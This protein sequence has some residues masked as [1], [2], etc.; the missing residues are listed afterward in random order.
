MCVTVS[1]CVRICVLYLLGREAFVLVCASNFDW[2]PKRLRSHS[3]R[4]RDAPFDAQISSEQIR[5]SNTVLNAFENVYQLL[6]MHL[7][8]THH[9]RV[10]EI[11]YIQYSIFTE[12]TFYICLQSQVSL[13]KVSLILVIDNSKLNEQKFVVGLIGDFKELTAVSFSILYTNLTNT[14]YYI[15]YIT[16]HTYLFNKSLTNER[17]FILNAE[18]LTNS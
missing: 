8:D 15:V 10:N 5:N 13:I 18:A 7:P 9:D 17:F 3:V 14:N 16:C 6:K 11:V 12:V 4:D 1:V 2:L